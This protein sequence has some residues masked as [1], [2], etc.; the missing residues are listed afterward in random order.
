[1]N[2]NKSVILYF[3]ICKKNFENHVYFGISEFWDNRKYVI[4]GAIYLRA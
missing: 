4:Y 2:Y 1:M 3:P